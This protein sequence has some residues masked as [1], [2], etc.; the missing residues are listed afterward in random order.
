MPR[1]VGVIAAAVLG[2][3]VAF[4][5]AWGVLSSLTGAPAANPADQ[6]VV[7]YGTK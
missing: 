1:T 2:A 3:V 5:A 7:V 6:P 4:L